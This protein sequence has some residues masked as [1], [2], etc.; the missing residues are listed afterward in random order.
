[1]LSG[2]RLNATLPLLY[3]ASY[4]CPAMRWLTKDFYPW[5]K[6]KLAEQGLSYDRRHDC[7]NFA[8]KFCVYAQ[9]AHALTQGGPQDEGLAVG[10]FLYVSAKVGP[11]AI[12]VAFVENMEMIFIEPQTGEV[13]NL[14]PEEIK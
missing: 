4:A 9:D 8:R 14:T 11:H 10:E 5:F 1:M 2:V 3:D 6:A 13:L 7:D 12:V